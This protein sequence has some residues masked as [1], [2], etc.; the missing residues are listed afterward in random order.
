MNELSFLW[1]IRPYFCLWVRLDIGYF[2]FCKIPYK[3]PPRS[4]LSIL[5]SFFIPDSTVTT[6]YLTGILLGAGA[7]LGPNSNPSVWGFDFSK[8]V[9]LIT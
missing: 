1:P 5:G 3:L 8:P 2:E 4:S 9:R 7:K 6:I